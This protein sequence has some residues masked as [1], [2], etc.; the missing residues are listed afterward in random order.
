MGGHVAE[1]EALAVNLAR[2][3]AENVLAENVLADLDGEATET[4]LVP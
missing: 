2:A 1:E 4:A 3:L